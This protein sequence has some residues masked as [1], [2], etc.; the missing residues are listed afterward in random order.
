MP[1]RPRVMNKLLALLAVL[2]LPLA[3][4]AQFE[5]VMNLDMYVW[6]LSAQ[7]PCEVEEGWTIT[8]VYAVGDTVTLELETPAL[9]GGF[10]PALTADN[11][12]TKSLWIQ[13]LSQYGQIWSDLLDRTFEEMRWF[14]LALRPNG[15]KD[16]SCVLISPTELGTILAKD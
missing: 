13:H 1:K 12:K 14:L 2:L 11:E 3:G 10:L 7:C 8:T 16:T 9:L 4:Y 15:G 5:G 6:Q